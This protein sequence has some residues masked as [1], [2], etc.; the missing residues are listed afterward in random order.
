MIMGHKTVGSERCVSDSQPARGD[1]VQ[2][3][4]TKQEMESAPC[5]SCAW[6][7]VECAIHMFAWGG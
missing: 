4:L 1:G 7:G 6:R 3:V 5:A 2:P